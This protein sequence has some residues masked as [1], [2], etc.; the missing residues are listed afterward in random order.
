MDIEKI[1]TAIDGIDEEYLLDAA[2]FISGKDAYMKNE[3]NINANEMTVVEGYEKKRMGKVTKWLSVAA[4]LCF[5]VAG[6]AVI[7]ISAGNNQIGTNEI[8][9]M[10]SKVEESETERPDIEDVLTSMEESSEEEKTEEEILFEK[11]VA[12]VTAVNETRYIVDGNFRM[13][14]QP[15]V[16]GEEIVDVEYEGGKITVSGDFHA[17]CGKVIPENASVGYYITVN[18]VVQ[19]LFVGEESIG[20]MYIHSNKKE[21]LENDLAKGSLKVSFVPTIGST[22]KDMD[23]LTVRLVTVR[24]PNFRVPE[25]YADPKVNHISETAAVWK[26]DVGDAA[27]E[28]VIETQTINYEKTAID[29]TAQYYGARLF[30]ANGNEFDIKVEG[31]SVSLKA[32]LCALET[33]EAAKYRIVYLVNGVPTALADGTPYIEVDAEYG[34]QYDFDAVTIDGVQPYDTVEV[35]GFAEA[36]DPMVLYPSTFMHHVLYPENFVRQ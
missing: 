5:I 15:F 26:L 27:I 14:G 32:Q 10:G 35:I 7:G 4:V 33:K 22:D 3:K 21:E 29:E 24:N 28:N 8:V 1:K 13:A 30:D 11:T 25:N 16:M 12:E 6:V 20:N 9:P 23:E 34:Y 2:E 19:E 31:T 18:G 17:E 36:E